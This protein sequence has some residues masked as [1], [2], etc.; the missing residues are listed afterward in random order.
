MTTSA[1]HTPWLWDAEGNF[2]TALKG[3][4]GPV[5]SAGFSPDGTHIMT[6]SADGTARSWGVWNDVDVMLKEALLRVRRS[7]T[8][9]ECQQYLHLETCPEN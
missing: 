5:W 6:A 9:A 3:H 2:L 4:T 7:L 8:E 1:D